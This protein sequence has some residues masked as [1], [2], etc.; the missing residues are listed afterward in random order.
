MEEKYCKPNLVNTRLR[1]A[2]VSELLPEQ[3]L[4]ELNDFGVIIEQTSN[5]YFVKGNQTYK[6]PKVMIE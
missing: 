4:S 1:R 5:G 6:L 3:I 2:F